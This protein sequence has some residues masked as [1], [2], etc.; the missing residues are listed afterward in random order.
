MRNLGVGRVVVLFSL[1]LA[2]RSALAQAPPPQA[3]PPPVV[4]P[5]ALEQRR[6]N[7]EK[8]IIPDDDTKREIEASGLS[9]LVATYK[10]CIN[11]A[12]AV[13][14]VEMLKSSGFPP[15]DRKLAAGMRTWRYRPY[16][17]EG[18]PV[19]VCTSVTFIYRQRNSRPAP[20]QLPPPTELRDSGYVI[21]FLGRALYSAYGAPLQGVR[22]HAGLV[23]V[24]SP[25][26]RVPAESERIPLKLIAPGYELSLWSRREDAAIVASEPVRL[27]ETPQLVRD[28]MGNA[29]LTFLPGVRLRG[30]APIQ[31]LERREGL[32][33]V[34]FVE[35]DGAAEGWISATSISKFAAFAA[36]SSPKGEEVLLSLGTPLL[37]AP[38]GKA[39]AA[40]ATSDARFSQKA[41]VLDRR[42]EHVLVALEGKLWR[43][44][45]WVPRSALVRPE[46][47]QL[48][49]DL[50]EG[51]GEAAP[52]ISIPPST[53]LYAA[54]YGDLI[55]HA[56]EQRSEGVS[57][58]RQGYSRI[59]ITTNVGSISAW[60]RGKP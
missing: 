42:E 56:I 44:V 51:A 35:G 17:L 50:T 39:L 26:G 57:E 53:P 1:L 5:T 12:G 18:K 29:A 36:A 60:I 46:H 9:K 13:M 28:G 11:V 6:I 15:Y 54:P 25:G 40:L 10:I 49:P 21:H 22:L 33:K 37:A 16:T 47:A 48:A 27:V 52:T 8:V 34:R 20:L 14:S 41:R 2:T 19:S 45:G 3:P 55:G 31:V 59:S 23:S 4:A 32:A 58:Q 38:R 7:G 24:L 30:G 43:A